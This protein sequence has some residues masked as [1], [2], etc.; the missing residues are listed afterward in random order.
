MEFPIHN[1]LLTVVE[2][3]VF[4]LHGPNFD[5]RV[6]ALGLTVATHVA[7]SLCA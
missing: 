1:I 3:L 2:L 6:G 5:A 7:G 4:E